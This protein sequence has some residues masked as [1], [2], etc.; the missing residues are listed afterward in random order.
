MSDHAPLY[1]AQI[2]QALHEVT[3]RLSRA[4]KVITDREAAMLEAKRHYDLAKDIAYKRAE[5]SVRDR[6]AQANIDTQEEREAYEVAYIAYKY[7]D[8][9]ARAMERQQST[10]QTNAKLTLSMFNAAGVGER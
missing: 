3:N 8:R 10:L 5:G 4:P 2:D 9:E 1:P 6:E 7:A